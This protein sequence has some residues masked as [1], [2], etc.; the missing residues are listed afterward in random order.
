MLSVE[1]AKKLKLKSSALI[2]RDLVELGVFVNNFQA[3]EAMRLGELQYSRY[4]KCGKMVSKAQLVDYLKRQ[5]QGIAVKLN[6]SMENYKYIQRQISND[7]LL[8]SSLTV[9][10]VVNT[11]VDYFHGNGLLIS[12]KRQQLQNLNQ[13]LAA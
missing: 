7:Q 11:M 1:A 10:Q 3:Y 6:L 13:N 12:N 9:E 2:A 8:D 5:Y 4:G